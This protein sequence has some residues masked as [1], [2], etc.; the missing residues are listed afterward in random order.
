MIVGNLRISDEVEVYSPNGKCSYN[1]RRV[2]T[3]ITPQPI[4]VNLFL[5]AGHAPDSSG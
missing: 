1:L 2:P 5:I 4:L 3:P